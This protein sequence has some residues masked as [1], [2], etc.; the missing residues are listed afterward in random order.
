[1]DSNL[2]PFMTELAVSW[3]LCAAGILFVI[4]VIYLRVTDRELTSLLPSI[5]FT[6]DLILLVI[7]QTPKRPL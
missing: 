7:A 4:P 6:A 3:G 5:L 1:M 2:A